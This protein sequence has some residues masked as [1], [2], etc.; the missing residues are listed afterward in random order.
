MQVLPSAWEPWGFVLNEGMEFGLPL[1]VSGAVGAGPD[2]V[3]QGENGFVF[4]TGSVNVL[5]EKLEVLIRDEALRKKMGEA[6]RKIIEDFSP[7]NWA[8]GVKR[9]IETVAEK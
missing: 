5:A 4:P 8:K 2:L 7:E 6:S 1:I 3:R 9:A